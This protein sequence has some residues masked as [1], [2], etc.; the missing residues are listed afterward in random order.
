MNNLNNLKQLVKELSIQ[1]NELQKV[2]ISYGQIKSKVE[3]EIYTLLK[4]HN[5]SMDEIQK[6]I[7]ELIQNKDTKTDNEGESLITKEK[8][9]FFKEDKGGDQ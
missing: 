8:F 2:F 3:L 5:M 1:E 4:D 6:T 7:E 9:K